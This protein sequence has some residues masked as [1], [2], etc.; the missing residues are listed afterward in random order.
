MER[1]QGNSHVLPVSYTHLD[2]YKRQ[3]IIRVEHST[4][5]KRAEVQLSELAD[6]EEKLFLQVNGSKVE[7]PRLI[8]VNEAFTTP[9]YSVAEGDMVEM[10]IRD[11]LNGPYRQKSLA[12]ERF[13][14]PAWTVMVPRLAMILN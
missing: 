13:F 5:G 14:L 1:K 3:D 2:V 9:D 6:K 10:C 11:R 7:L 4:A 12:Q 8:L